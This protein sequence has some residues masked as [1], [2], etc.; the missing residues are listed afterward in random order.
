ML[1]T[2]SSS[3]FLPS[4]ILFRCH[5]QLSKMFFLFPDPHFKARKHKARI[6]S[7]AIPLLAQNVLIKIKTLIETTAIIPKK[8]P[9]IVIGIRIYFKAEWDNLHDHGREGF[10]RMDGKASQR[11][12][13]FQ[14]SRGGGIDTSRPAGRSTHQINLQSHRRR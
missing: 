2:V 9:H 10:E 8:K 12:S 13:A 11:P 4:T 7:S 3:W 5:M 1:C 14:A 6:I